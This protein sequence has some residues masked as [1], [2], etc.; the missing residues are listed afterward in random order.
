MGHVPV[1][2]VCVVNEVGGGKYKV[3][4]LTVKPTGNRLLLL[5]TRH[6]AH[7]CLV[8]RDRANTLRLAGVKNKRGDS[9]SM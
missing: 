9:M 4:P 7:G 8:R 2:M 6:A 5:L 3:A 1:C